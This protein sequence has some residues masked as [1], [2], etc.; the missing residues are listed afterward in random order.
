[1]FRAGLKIQII[2]VILTVLFLN[3][4]KPASPAPSRGKVRLGNRVV[5][6]IPSAGKLDADERAAMITRRLTGLIGKNWPVS[7]IHSE[8]KGSAFSILWKDR[9]IIGI[10]A[11]MARMNHSLPEDLAGIWVRSLKEAVQEYSLKVS[12]KAMVLPVGGTDWFDISG[13]VQGDITVSYDPAVL[14]VTVE[15][16]TARVTVTALKAAR[17][18]I[19]VERGVCRVGIAVTIKEWAGSVPD[20]AEVQV[21]GLPAPR[22]LLSQAA[23]YVANSCLELKPGARAFLRETPAIPE[24]LPAGDSTVIRLPLCLEG[25]DYFPLEKTISVSMRNVPISSAPTNLLLVSNRPE[26][27]SRAGILFRENISGDRCTR[28]LYSHKNESD[29][30]R[31]FEV[32]LRNEKNIPVQLWVLNTRA[33]P[34]RDSLFVGHKAAVRFLDFFSKRAGFLVRVP[35]GAEAPLVQNSLG[36]QSSIAG[37]LEF[38]ILEG[39]ELT[40]EV[41][42]QDSTSYVASLPLLEEPFDPFLIHPRGSFREPDLSVSASY[43]AGSGEKTLDLVTG[44]WLID[45]KTGEPNVGNYGSIYE[46]NLSL[47]NP[48][49]AGHRIQI[50][51][52]PAGG[53]ASGSFIIEDNLLETPPVKPPQQVALGSIEMSPGEKRNLRIYTLPESGSFYPVKI[54][55]KSDPI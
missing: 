3:I 35:P 31:I 22:E 4:G 18:E 38:Q 51:F 13:M 25:D 20:S 7:D 33:G 43:L 1:M 6:T 54:L 5:M 2:V 12:R 47:E 50:Y 11:S 46:I 10:D 16:D 27:F 53:I 8:K 32:V 40:L 34:D 49:A 15:P 26:G 36:A 39:E 44:P 21:T 55:M 24:S 37:V 14:S 19:L 9:L 48:T 45:H 30:D 29:R 42:A 23:L 17:S 28:L 52:V 41:K